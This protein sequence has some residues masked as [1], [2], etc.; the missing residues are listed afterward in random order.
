MWKREREWV[1]I[2]YLCIANHDLVCD[3]LDVSLHLHGLIFVLQSE[4]LVFENLAFLFI[5]GL[6]TRA[7]RLLLRPLFL[8]WHVLV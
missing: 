5:Y 7:L 8:G 4:G 3:L 1:A 6:S 2:M